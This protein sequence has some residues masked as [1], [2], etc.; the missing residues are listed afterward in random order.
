MVGK[1]EVIDEPRG[2]VPV[3]RITGHLGPSTDFS[4]NGVNRPNARD[5]SETS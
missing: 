1:P 5:G 4:G 3:S 2:Q